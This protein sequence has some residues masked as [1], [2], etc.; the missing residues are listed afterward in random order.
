MADHPYLQVESKVKDMTLPPVS[1]SKIRPVRPPP[2]VKSKGK[3]SSTNGPRGSHSKGPRAARLHKKG[4]SSGGEGHRGGG[5]GGGG[6]S[7]VAKG[8]GSSKLPLLKVS[9][10]QK[11]GS[12]ARSRNRHRLIPSPV[13]GGEVKREHLNAAKGGRT[14]RKPEASGRPRHHRRHH[15]N[16]RRRHTR[17]GSRGDARADAVRALKE[18]ELEATQLVKLDQKLLEDSSELLRQLDAS[19]SRLTSLRIG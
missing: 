18:A 4:D 3:N 9:R 13:S 17:G 5:G 1:M 6:S 12:N 16:R 14:L 7:S 11:G 10:R 2:K 19:I 15:R 8:P